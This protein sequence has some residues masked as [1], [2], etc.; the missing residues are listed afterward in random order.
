MRGVLLRG[1]RLPANRSAGPARPPVVPAAVPVPHG[2]AMRSA[3]LPPPHR[4]VPGGPYPRETPPAG[5]LLPAKAPL[6]RAPPAGPGL[7]EGLQPLWHLARDRDKD[8]CPR[9]GQQ[10]MMHRRPMP[11]PACRRERRAR[12]CWQASPHR[13]CPRPGTL[14]PRAR[15]RPEPAGHTICPPAPGP[16]VPPGPAL[17]VL[18]GPCPGATSSPVRPLSATASAGPWPLP[19]RTRSLADLAGQHLAGTG[20]GRICVL[21]GN[22]AQPVAGHVVC[23][24]SPIT[25]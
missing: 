11:P 4:A 19:S 8:S 20:Y 15:L 9:I 18:A 10:P 5:V 25:D 1:R 3:A 6:M 21:T 13:T 7:P 22:R 2:A 24:Q 17:R 16:V 23:S 14:P 12:G